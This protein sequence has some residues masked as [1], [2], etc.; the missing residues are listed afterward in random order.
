VKDLV[1]LKRIGRSFHLAEIALKK[2]SA[3]QS[4]ERISVGLPLDLHIFAN[5]L[6][7][8]NS[9]NVSIKTLTHSINIQNVIDSI[10]EDD[11]FLYHA[12]PAVPPLMP[13]SQIEQP[14]QI[15]ESRTKK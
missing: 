3:L 2:L 10:T 13:P 1:V 5:Y 6:L 8:N 15:K 14:Q 7:Y 4:H 9:N 12:P 11:I